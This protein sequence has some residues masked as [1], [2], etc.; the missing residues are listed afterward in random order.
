MANQ[1]QKERS[2]YGQFSNGQGLHFILNKICPD[3]LVVAEEYNVRVEAVRG[4]G[5]FGQVLILDRPPFVLK[6]AIPDPL[7]DFW[8]RVNWRAKDFP[9]Q[10]SELDAKLGSVKT[11]LIHDAVEPIT[12]GVFYAPRSFGYTRLPGTFAQAVERLYGRPPR[13]D[14][15][16]DEFRLFRKAQAQLTDIAYMLGLEHAGQVHPDN[17]FA[18]ANIW[19]NPDFKRWEWLDT[20][21]AIRHTGLVLPMPLPFKFHDQIRRRFYPD[22]N[23]VTFDRIHT[24]MYLETVRQNEGLFSKEILEDW[25]MLQN[26][27]QLLLVKQRLGEPKKFF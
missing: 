21:P 27:R 4:G 5:F 7:H 14:N 18:M 6:T 26:I 10:D 24:G 15:H 13:Y 23:D 19:W 8:R 11:D 17:P 2:P 25:L 20:L 9:Y 12:Q 3:G 1:E 22:T 16:Q